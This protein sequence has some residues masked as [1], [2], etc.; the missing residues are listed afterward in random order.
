M[1][2]PLSTVKMEYIGMGKQS[3]YNSKSGGNSNT[4]VDPTKRRNPKT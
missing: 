2:P 3:V 1:G 4:L